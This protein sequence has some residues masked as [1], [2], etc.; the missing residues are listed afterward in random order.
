MKKLFAMLVPALVCSPIYAQD[1]LQ[2]CRV[3]VAKEWIAMGA[4]TLAGC[5]KFADEAAT[6]DE[7]QFAKVGETFL[8]IEGGVH[9]QSSDGGNTWEPLMAQQGA[10]GF[11]SL[12][13]LQPSD[14]AS[15]ASPANPS[16]ADQPAPVKKKKKKKRR[17]STYAH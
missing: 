6:P 3:L 7:R 5:L 4:T 1:G 14:R 16:Q 2:E 13:V 8:K 9:F 12:N 17:R 15:A 10:V 11:S